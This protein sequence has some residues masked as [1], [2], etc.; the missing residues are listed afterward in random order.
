MNGRPWTEEELSLLRDMYPHCATEDVAEWLGRQPGSVSQAALTRG[1]HKT[2]EYLASVSSGRIRRGQK[3]P[4]MKGTQFRPGMTPWN[5]GKHH[6]PPGSEKGRFK[7]GHKNPHR[8]LP[9]GSYRINT[10]G[11]LERK[12]TDLGKGPRDW[13]SVHR[14]V[15][16]EQGVIPPGHIVIFRPGMKTN[17]LE[18]ITVDRL[19]CI[20]RAE[21]ARRNSLY[22]RNP[23][24]GRLAQLKGAIT[25][26]VNRI[27]QEAQT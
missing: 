2:A 9:I 20:S 26:Q 6:S 12:V 15:W 10:E 18:E 16:K 5:K 4:R 22:T 19:E 7:A 8:W 14:L 27:I 11:L 1:I 24:L 25:R 23:E 3:D 21:N 17:R 13:E